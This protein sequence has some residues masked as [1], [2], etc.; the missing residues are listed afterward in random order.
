MIHQGILRFRGGRYLWWAIALVLGS[1]LLYATHGGGVQP[2]G[3]TW[4][5][6]VLGTVA[7]AL[8]FW[9]A[10]LGVR[11]R[12]YSS[13]VGT[14][15]G[16]T[17]AHVYLGLAVLVVATLHSAAQVGWNVHTLSYVLLWLVVL[18]GAVGIQSYVMLPRLL[19][20]NREGG[21]RAQMFAELV[22]L[23]RQARA[24]TGRCTPAIAAA[25]AA[26][27]SARSSAAAS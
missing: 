21:G 17:S 6:Y 23:D 22:E 24:L 10:F 14:V 19:A 7:G 26:A 1:T 2:S 13:T 25:I 11:K 8:V 9:L 15:E 27:S 4:Q 3:D 12:R 5:G 20:R 16:W 18:S